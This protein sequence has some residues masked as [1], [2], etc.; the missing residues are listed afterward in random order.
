MKRFRAGGKRPDKTDWERLRNMS[1]EEIESAA[2]SDPENP[3]A[4]ADWFRRARA[5][6]PQPKQA[7]SLR[8]DRDVLEWFKKRGR[9]YQTR[10][11]AVLRAYMEAHQERR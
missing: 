9:G 1:E 5:V 2:E 3:P 4:S 6:M 10:M 8:A 7:V 11:N